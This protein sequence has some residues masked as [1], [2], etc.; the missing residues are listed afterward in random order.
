MFRWTPAEDEKLKQIY[1]KAEKAVL[2]KQFGRNYQAIWL[3]AKK[4]GVAKPGGSKHHWSIKECETLFKMTELMNSP[5]ELAD[6]LPGITLDDMMA[7]GKKLGCDLC[8]LNRWEVIRKSVEIVLDVD[9]T[10]NFK[11]VKIA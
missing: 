5:K 11:S 1:G 6:A 8:Y 2:E 4:L 3:R 7:Q 9:L 10:L